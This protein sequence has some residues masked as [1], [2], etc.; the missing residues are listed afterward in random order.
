MQTASYAKIKERSETGV[1]GL[2]GANIQ[3]IPYLST[4]ATQDK[5][6][7]RKVPIDKGQGT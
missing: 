2:I 6:K 4:L 1:V 7:A 5:A 3:S